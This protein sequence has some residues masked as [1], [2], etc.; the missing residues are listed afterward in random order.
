MREPI[1]AEVTQST[2]R[3]RSAF[4]RLANAN[5]TH[6]NGGADHNS[7][8]LVL[9]AS[10]S[11]IFVDIGE[12]DTAKARGLRRT[13]LSRTVSFILATQPRDRDHNRR[14][15]VWISPRRQTRAAAMRRRGLASSGVCLCPPAT[16]H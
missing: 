16:H 3:C 2:A 5:W 14:R 13:W 10:L 8:Q 12:G 1:R 4:R 11:Q 6:R 9:A 15:A 7:A